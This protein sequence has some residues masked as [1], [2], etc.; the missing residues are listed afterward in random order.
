[1]STF[2]PY[3]RAIKESI[4]VD[5]RDRHSMQK[6]ILCNRENQ[7]YG[8]FIGIIK[9]NGA[10]ITN[11]ILSNVSLYN[12]V[13]YDKE[14]NPID[15]TQMAEDMYAISDAIFETIP[16]L[17]G[18]IDELSSNIIQLGGE[19][20]DFQISVFGM[21]DRLD[22]RIDEEIE[23]RQIEDGKIILMFDEKT[24][25]L[26]SMI[27]Y[28]SGEVSCQNRYFNKKID[29]TYDKLVEKIL[30][31]RHYDFTDYAP[32][33]TV[34]T[35]EPQKTIVLKD[36]SVN[37]MVLGATDAY[38]Y[39][40]GN[41]VGRI[42]NSKNDNEGK[43]SSFMFQVFKDRDGVDG[44]IPRTYSFSTNNFI[45]E[46]EEDSQITWMKNTDDKYLMEFS[47][48]AKPY[49]VLSAE[50][51]GEAIT[52]GTVQPYDLNGNSLVSG[53]ASFDTMAFNGD[54]FEF[55]N[56]YCYK[57]FQADTSGKKNRRIIFDPSGN[58][59][60][61][62][63]ILR[64]NFEARMYQPLNDESGEFGR[65]YE[66]QVVY[67]DG[68]ILES[69]GVTASGL[70]ATLN[71]ENGFR[72]VLSGYEFAKLSSDELDNKTVVIEHESKWYSRDII[73]RDDNNA[74][75]GKVII[76]V[77]NIDD[78][79]NDSVKDMLQNAV[80]VKIDTG[81]F[82][83][84]YKLTQ[85]RSEETNEVETYGVIVEAPQPYLGHFGFFINKNLSNILDFVHRM[86]NKTVYG[87]F[88]IDTEITEDD[89]TY[90]VHEC[91]V[92]ED[93]NGKIKFDEEDTG[94]TT[95]EYVDWF[96][97]AS[98]EVQTTELKSSGRKQFISIGLPE[99][100]TY[101]GQARSREFILAINMPDKKF[102]FT[103][104]VFNDLDYKFI[105]N[106]IDVTR[107]FGFFGK[108]ALYRF[109]ETNTEDDGKTFAIEDMYNQNLVSYINERLH[110]GVNYRGVVQVIDHEVEGGWWKTPHLSNLFYYPVKPAD[111]WNYPRPEYEGHEEL[112]LLNGNMFYVGKTE[113][114]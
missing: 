23:Q 51:E 38:I 96:S 58:D 30:N 72:N 15:L 4:N 41:I 45:V 66:D 2:N 32:D 73:D 9:A 33:S 74:H 113:N 103:P 68:G 55:G 97:P 84:T 63:F 50:S 46:V 18:K 14:G 98:N 34:E 76:G 92:S 10:T 3:N 21:R 17:S 80:S 108:R 19:C 43:V 11:G 25:E 114:T 44:L 47:F 42:I 7:F 106:G 85:K 28:L 27:D 48:P 102:E 31:D 64:D 107:K 22:N 110:G 82:I 39:A 100:I 91:Q 8:E 71:D 54:R 53:V 35:F 20:R 99:S 77:E 79:F 26:S 109:V 56:E 94:G 89:R 86:P 88:G 49:L 36:Y 93:E 5:F 62:Q 104:I 29:E 87:H 112:P 59:G 65:I 81:T 37:R 1:M 60:V 67:G 69:I 6:V 111:D 61:G 83:G 105:S 95:T 12:T 24:L 78:I 13:L 52:Y 40:D 16:Y 75:I 70:T 57:D 90:T 101:N